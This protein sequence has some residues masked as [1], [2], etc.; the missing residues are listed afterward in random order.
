MPTRPCLG[1]DET[2]LSTPLASGARSDSIARPN[3]LLRRYK[4]AAMR[5]DSGSAKVRTNEGSEAMARPGL[6]PVARLCRAVVP[7][8]GP[9]EPAEMARPG[10]EP[11]ARLCRA[12]VPGS[13]PGEPAE[14]AR[15]G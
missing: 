12:V 7:G 1:T 15:P 14:M 8:S 5:R 6:E 4:L 2:G 3:D 10:L 11:V 9:G 13:G